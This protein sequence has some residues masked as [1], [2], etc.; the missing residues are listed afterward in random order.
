MNEIFMRNIILQTDRILMRPISY[1]DIDG[2]RQIAFD[3]EIWKFNVFRIYDESELRDFLEK[4]IKGRE[5]QNRYAFTIIDKLSGRIAG[6]TSYSNIS[7]PDKRLEIGWT[8]LG[9]EFQ[10]TGINKVCKYLLLNYAFNE[11]NYYRVEFKTDFLNQKSKKA[12]QKIGAVEEGILRSH[13]KMHDGRRRD[14]VYYSI[15]KPEWSELRLKI[16]SEFKNNM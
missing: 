4:A 3:K 2:L 16:F 8:W 6:S 12:L 10:G 14:T 11:L 7:E 1:D 13:T 15:L 9:T 5:S